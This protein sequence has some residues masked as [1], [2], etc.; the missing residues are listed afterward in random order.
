VEFNIN[1]YTYQEPDNSVEPKKVEYNNV[2][3]KDMSMYSEG[4]QFSF[5]DRPDM[6][7][8]IKRVEDG[9]IVFSM[10]DQ[11]YMMPE[12]EFNSTFFIK[13]VNS[14]QNWY[15]RIKNN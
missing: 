11:T 1:D 13:D 4:V 7:G 14:P 15:T 9:Q 2:D 12:H 10:F 3:S 5:R 6:S 8:N